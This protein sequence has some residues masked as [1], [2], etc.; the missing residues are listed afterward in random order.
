MRQLRLRRRLGQLLLHQ[1]H[2]AAMSRSTG[3]VQG[4]EPVVRRRTSRHG[5]NAVNG[6]RGL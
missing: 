2:T 5:Y 1:T 3:V 4:V 6:L